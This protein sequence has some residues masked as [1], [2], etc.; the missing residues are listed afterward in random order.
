MK[1][2]EHADADDPCDYHIRM[3]HHSM[4]ALLDPTS[5]ALGGSPRQ[6]VNQNVAYMESAI[7][8]AGCRDCDPQLD[9]IP[10]SCAY[11]LGYGHS[12]MSNL[13][14]VTRKREFHYVSNSIS[15]PDLGTQLDS[16][17]KLVGQLN[18]TNILT[19]EEKKNTH[20]SEGKNPKSISKDSKSGDSGA[21]ACAALDSLGAD[22]K[23]K[24]PTLSQ[25]VCVERGLEKNFRILESGRCS[26]KNSTATG[27]VE[28]DCDDGRNSALAQ[29]RGLR[30]E[31]QE[32][33]FSATSGKDC[34][35]AIMILTTP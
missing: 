29:G 30:V 31:V 12:Q 7:A 11:G 34:R 5:L 25:L 18:L 33:M 22:L 9:S 19:L 13:E 14:S 23:G 15:L 27:R 24:F 3:A 21:V 6:N 10:S 1:A 26:E 20:Q 17:G 2:Q 8:P 16:F 4:L 28:L 32:L 35:T